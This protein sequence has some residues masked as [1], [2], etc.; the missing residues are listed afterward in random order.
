H[1]Q[2]ETVHPFIDGNGRTGR[3]LVHLIFQRRSLVTQTVVPVS[4][5]LLADPDSYFDGLELYRRGALD[6]WV[7]MF[8][9][10]AA[11]AATSGAQLGGQLRDIA[12]DWNTTAHP[13][14]GSAVKKLLDGLV[15]QPVVD[16][17]QVA[18]LC[19][20]VASTNLHR[21]VNRLVEAGILAPITT[22]KRNQVWAATDV[23]DLLE[24]FEKDV[25]GRRKPSSTAR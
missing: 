21:A 4:T 19:P 24:R 6:E 13:R 17:D 9:A 22:G 5:V 14:A 23:I 15:R 8:A 12:D 25:I 16:I 7:Q 10:A 2:F 20:G 11:L 1:A 18:K 3:A